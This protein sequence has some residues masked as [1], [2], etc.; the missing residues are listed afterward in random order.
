MINCISNEKTMIIRQII[1][2]IK[3]DIAISWVNIFLNQM[4]VLVK[5]WKM[6]SI[7]L[8]MQQKQIWGATGVPTDLSKLII[9]EYNY[10]V[11]KTVYD[12]LFSKV[13]VIDTSGFSL[14]T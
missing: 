12:K 13:K 5:M 6:N 4:K 8:I 1:G 14:K 10:V 2:L 11:K 9:V 7:C 3:K